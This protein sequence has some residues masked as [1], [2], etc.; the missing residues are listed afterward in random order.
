MKP[1]PCC[2]Q[3]AVLTLIVFNFASAQDINF[4]DMKR[5]GK[6]LA[7][8]VMITGL[9]VEAKSNLSRFDE[10]DNSRV[11]QRAVDMGAAAQRAAQ[12]PSQSTV[13]AAPKSSGKRF[14]CEAECTN[15]PSNIGSEPLVGKV[16][17]SIN[18]SDSN[19]ARLEVRS[20]AGDACKSNFGGSAWY[21]R[22]GMM[23]GG[24][25]YIN[26]REAR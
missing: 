23:S 25:D 8:T 26:C 9:T 15:R 21:R 3:I 12:Q 18:S 16:V 10:I 2:L 19:S 7:K 22:A 1:F 5:Q 4:D 11:A 24:N 17:V 14:T 20:S 6:P 13:A